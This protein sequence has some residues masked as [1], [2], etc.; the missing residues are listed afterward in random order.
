MQRHDSWQPTRYNTNVASN[1][2]YEQPL[3]ERVR[4]FLRVE[5]LF[6]QL[7]HY[8][9][10]PNEWNNR[11]AISALIEVIDFL[12]RLDIKTELIKELERHSVIISSLENTP[13]VDINRLK[14]IIGEISDCL[15]T[16]R[17]ASF[18][19]G[20]ALRQNEFITSIKQRASIPGGTCNFDLPGYYFWL[21]SQNVNKTGQLK[22]WKGDISIIHRAVKLALELIRNSTNPVMATAIRGF[23]QQGIETDA[24]CQLIRVKLPAGSG[25]YPEI[26]GG[27]HRFT[28]RFME[29][30]SMNQR[31]SQTSD[32]VEFELHC[33]SL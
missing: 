16:L 14:M 29:Q 6:E 28:I 20:Q 8:I 12:S 9:D 18:Q 2:S 13:G 3:N 31:P 1:I 15:K 19:P 25:Y 4:T 33:C 11:N 32:D 24:P 17:D 7:N 27:K 5:F 21:K 10:D 23:Y 30:P 22:E 26:S